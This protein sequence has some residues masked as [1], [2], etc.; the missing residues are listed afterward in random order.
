MRK[1]NIVIFMNERGGRIKSKLSLDVAW[2]ALFSLSSFFDLCFENIFHL[3]FP[4]NGTLAPSFCEIRPL[5][6]IQNFLFHFSP[7]DRRRTYH[8]TSPSDRRPEISL[9]PSFPRQSFSL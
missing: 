4:K 1:T 6:K 3:F 9:A 2:N 7:T 5:Q 8:P